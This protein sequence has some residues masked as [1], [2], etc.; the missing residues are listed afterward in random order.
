MVAVSGTSY[1]HVRNAGLQVHAGYGSRRFALSDMTHVHL[2]IYGAVKTNGE[3]LAYQAPV[4]I[5][6]V[7]QG[8]WRCKGPGNVASFPGSALPVCAGA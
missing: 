3:P 4:E 2:A 7:R 6:F 8:Q 5:D 1:L